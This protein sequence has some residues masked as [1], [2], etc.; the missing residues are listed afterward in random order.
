MR[1]LLFILFTCCITVSSIAGKITGMVTNQNGEPLPYSSITIKGSKEATSA[2]NEGVYFLQLPAGTYTI[3]CR[4][5]GFER[6]EKTISITNEDVQV[7]FVLKEQS[8]SLSEVVVKAGAEDPAYA[9]I[10]NAIKKRKEHLN[11]IKSYECEV[12]S[13]GTMS[14]RDFPKSFMGQKVDFEDGDTSKQK[15]L[16][17]SETISKLSVDEPNKVK[18]DVLSTRVS[19]QSDG[20]GFAGARFFSFYDNNVQ[21]S[22]SLNPR[23][24]IS[25]IAEN[26]LYF[27][28]YKYEGAFSEDGQLINKIKVIAKRGYEPCFTGYINIV[29][30]EWRIHSLELM[31][32]K[33]SQMNFADTLRIEQLY[34][35]IAVKHWVVQ[36]Q[37]LYPAVKLLGFD[38]YGSFANVYRNFNT[39]PVFEKKYFD[40]TILKY[41]KGSNKK[42][43]EYWDSIR[44]LAL[45][46]A[47]QIDY[48]KKDSLEQLRK[49]PAYLDSIDAANNKFK[50]SHIYTG[51]TY[52]KQTK[53]ISYSVPGLLTF[54]SFNTVEGVALDLPVT[55]RK[56]FTDRKNLTLIPH[57]RYAVNTKQFYAWGTARYNFG[58]RFFSSVSISGGKRPFQLNNDE[59]ILPLSNT[60]SSLLYKNNFLKLYLADYV[61]VNFSKGIGS[62]LTVTANLQYQDRHPLENTTDYSWNK[63]STRPYRPNYPIELQTQS[64]TAHQ[65]AILSVGVTFQPGAKYVEYPDRTI[66]VGSKWPTFSTQY[67]KGIADFL[68]SDVD[69]DKWQVAIRDNLNLKL[70]GRFN[71]RVQTGGFTNSRALYI[72]DMKHFPGNRLLLSTDFLTTFQLPQYYRFSN[73]DDFYTA[74]FTEHHFNGFLTNK[75][76]GIKKLN[77]H[78]VAGASVLWLPGQ[79][80]AEWHAGFEN[81]FRFFSVDVVTGYT[82]GSKP[83]TEVRF[84]TTFN[85]GGG[86]GND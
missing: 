66:N 81:I 68:G 49:D 58:T 79:T 54:V 78:L 20:F 50:I 51:K 59:P 30:D 65:A 13:K 40:N 43:I 71:Y 23:G 55:I 19:G 72:Q 6:Q 21:I 33:Q 36:S 9:I 32:T 1:S 14:L 64:F 4:H 70:A 5:V 24:F 73:A 57:L 7:N 2:N 76:P 18:V 63:K 69:Y 77:W 52:N 31:L 12:Y 3:I 42:S 82:Q 29:E 34:Q 47:E 35:K 61:R 85:I 8:V 41:E 22:N 46:N 74:V 67:T 16:Y 44:P 26:A 62:G 11:E 48:V 45:T 15:M 60:I 25:P 28:K 83:R 84:G 53:K 75:I 37:I 17:L 27:Y 80:Y 39:E 38:A 86:G 56:E 10:R